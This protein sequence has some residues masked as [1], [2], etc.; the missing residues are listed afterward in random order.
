MNTDHREFYNSENLEAVYDHRELIDE[1]GHYIHIIDKYYSSS[2]EFLCKDDQKMI[3]LF[4]SALLEYSKE[5]YNS[6]LRGNFYAAAM[7]NRAMIENYVCL[8]IVLDHP[9]KELWKYWEVHSYMKA[10]KRKN[11]PE[12][13]VELLK[14]CE[15]SGVDPS[16]LKKREFN[17]SK[18]WLLPVTRQLSMKSLCSLVDPAIY[19]DYQDLCD[20]VHGISLFQKQMTFT[21]Y[22]T[23]IPMFYRLFEYIACFSETC[24]ADDLDDEYWDSYGKI[25]DFTREALQKI[26]RWYEE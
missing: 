10:V 24:F 17:D 20:F 23:V 2:H 16:L 13:E 25:N 19:E 1:L 26:G 8:R 18:G 21:F 11:L 14:F 6:V 4:T 12:L 7:L 3:R 15:K 5:A 9:E 22:D